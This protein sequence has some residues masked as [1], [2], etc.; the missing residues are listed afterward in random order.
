MAE[1]IHCLNAFIQ[2][3]I[4]QPINC[5]NK[6]SAGVQFQFSTAQRLWRCYLARHSKIIYGRFT[7]TKE[8]A[9]WSRRFL[10][11]NL[12]SC[13]FVFWKKDT[14]LFREVKLQSSSSSVLYPS[15]LFE[16]FFKNPLSKYQMLHK[17]LAHPPQ[18]EA[19]KTAGFCSFFRRSVLLQSESG[20]QIKC[21]K[22]LKSGKVSSGYLEIYP[23]NQKQYFFD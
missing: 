6:T 4:K 17:K 23:L 20:S 9:K 11:Q 19:S 16:N 3:L 2:K 8:E 21:G 5:R 12:L 7:S 13:Y 22:S 10:R 1:L 15:G 14:Y 18:E